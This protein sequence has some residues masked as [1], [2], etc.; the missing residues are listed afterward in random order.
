MYTSYIYREREIHTSP[1]QHIFVCCCYQ[2]PLQY[3]MLNP[4]LSCKT[5]H[6]SGGACSR[7]AETTN[8]RQTRAEK[9]QNPGS[10]NSLP[11]LGQRHRRDLL[12]GVCRGLR[13]LGR[14]DRGP[15]VRATGTMLAET[16]L[17]DLAARAARV[18]NVGASARVALLRKYH[19]ET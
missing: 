9:Y 17:A 2:M 10:R 15:Q 4:H 14:G 1:L 5:W 16:M 13:Q 11:D 12:R 19:R 6:G 8:P 3:S 18:C 7:S